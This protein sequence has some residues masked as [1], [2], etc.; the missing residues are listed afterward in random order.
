MPFQIPFALP[1]QYQNLAMFRLLLRNSFDQPLG[2]GA[3]TDLN[4][5][6]EDLDEVGAHD[7]V[8]NNQRIIIPS[9]VIRAQF[10]GVIDFQAPGGGQRQVFMKKN[11]AA[12]NAGAPG[13]GGDIRE[14]ASAGGTA[15]NLST[16]I[17]TVATGDIFT[18]NAFQNSGGN[19]NTQSNFT[20]V[21]A[22]FWK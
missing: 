20:W 10:F 1:I 11:G 7:P 22:V 14:A 6:T 19:V 13:L 9:G 3:A 16:P 4:F 12:G 17:L 21:A 2:S 15:I 8:T 18:F 5:D